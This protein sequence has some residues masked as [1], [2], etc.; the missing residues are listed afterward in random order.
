[1][2]DVVER[3]PRARDASRGPADPVIVRLRTALQAAYGDRLKRAMLFGS[4]ARGDHR[5]DSDYDV[6]VFIERAEPLARELD[7]LAEIS[8]DI[9][10]DTGTVVSAKPF[11]AGA[12]HARTGF[13]GE[14]RREGRAL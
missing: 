4:R 14:L 10:L 8:T 6:A 7:R 2:A 13:M 5:P 1:M 11:P 3:F 12:W 9:L